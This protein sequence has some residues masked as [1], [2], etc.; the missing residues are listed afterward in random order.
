MGAGR[1]CGHLEKKVVVVAAAVAVVVRA[2]AGAAQMCWLEKNVE[3]VAAAVA[4]AVAVVVVRVRAVA[5]GGT[6]VLG[7]G[8]DLARGRAHFR[9][10]ARRSI[11]FLA[12]GFR[13]LKMTRATMNTFTLPSSVAPGFRHLKMARATTNTFNYNWRRRWWWWWWW[14]RRRRRR[15]W[16]LWCVDQFGRGFKKR[17][18]FFYEARTDDRHTQREIVGYRK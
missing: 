14:W 1:G 17:K 10:A 6:H 5:G 9:V 16:W 8:P 7:V 18:T 13:R 4:A 2:S 11:T 12:P 3:V 15:R